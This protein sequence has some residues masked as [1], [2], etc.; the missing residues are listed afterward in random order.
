LKWINL[1]TEAGEQDPTLVGVITGAYLFFSP[2]LSDL[3]TI[4]HQE[5]SLHGFYRAAVAVRPAQEGGDY[6]LRLSWPDDSRARELSWRHLNVYDKTL[7]Q[8]AKY[9]YWK[10]NAATERREYS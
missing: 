2:H 1:T 7:G 8:P 3:L 6:V 9:R 5:L 4:A 10:A